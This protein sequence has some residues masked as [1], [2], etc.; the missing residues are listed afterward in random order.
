MHT[1]CCTTKTTV[2]R[3]AVYNGNT[4]VCRH[5]FRFFVH[6]IISTTDDPPARSQQLQKIIIHV[7]HSQLNSVAS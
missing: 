6:S 3:A 1:D 5:I 7:L 4:A 2:C